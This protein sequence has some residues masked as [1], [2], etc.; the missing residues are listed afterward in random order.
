MRDISFHVKIMSDL[1]FTMAL[2][3][4]DHFLSSNWS[5]RMPLCQANPEGLGNNVDDGAPDPHWPEQCRLDA[6]ASS[7]LG[8]IDGKVGAMLQA[9]GCEIYN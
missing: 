2:L 4:V 3:V 1:I 8:A 6:G 5:I 7:T 9:R